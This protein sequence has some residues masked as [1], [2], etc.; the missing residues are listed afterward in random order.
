MPDAATLRVGVATGIPE[1]WGSALDRARAEAGDPLAEF[2]PAHVTL[3]G[4]TDV[5]AAS[6]AAI[7]D[8]LARVA[9][10]FGPFPVRLRGT[11][12][13]RP[14][15][16][17]VFVAV[18]AG[19]SEFEQLA[20][21]VRAGPLERELHFPYHPHVTV[22]H[23]IATEALDKVFDDLADFS[24]QFEVDQFTLYVHG[25]DGRWRPRRGYPLGGSAA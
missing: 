1:P 8:H 19:I 17:V 18:A 24:A 16:E 15:T 23:D 22:A 3:L 7:E 10:R 2:I 25:V 11:G 14:V 9:P 12:T 5:A 6:L 21:A 13:F 20:S 4:P